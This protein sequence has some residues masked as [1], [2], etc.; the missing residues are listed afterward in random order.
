ML[1]SF[2]KSTES[3]LS[4]ITPN[5]Y[6]RILHNIHNINPKSILN[7]TTLSHNELLLPLLR[8]GT[9]VLAESKV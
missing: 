8:I 1:Q 9:H 3:E 4:Y 2:S 5:A 7:F 6:A